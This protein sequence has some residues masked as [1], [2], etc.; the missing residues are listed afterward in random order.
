MKF[1]SLL[2]LLITLRSLGTWMHYNIERYFNHLETANDIPEMKQFLSF[3]EDHINAKAIQPYRT[4]WRIAAP[5]I[6]LAGSVDF[7][8]KMPDG[9]FCIMDWKR[10]KD[11][12]TKL[13][14]AYGKTAL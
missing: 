14:N 12:H 8:G 13:E 10:A 1:Y 5:D 3:Y 7:V 6:D 9:T 11:L 4:E 2:A